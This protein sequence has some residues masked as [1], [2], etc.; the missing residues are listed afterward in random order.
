MSGV[1]QLVIWIR[2][3]S[4]LVFVLTSGKAKGQLSDGST[5]ASFDF[6]AKSAKIVPRFELDSVHVAEKVAA[7]KRLGIP[8][9]YGIVEQMDVDIRAEGIKTVIGNTV[10]WQYELS[11]PDALSLGVHFKTYHLPEGA[12][13]FI[14][15]PDKTRLRGGFSNTNG[16]EGNQLMLGEFP[17]NRLVIEYDEPLDATFNGELVIGSVSKAYV[18]FASVARSNIQINCPEGADWQETKHAVCLMTFE[19][20]L[21]S[22]YCSGALVNNVSEDRTPY[23]LTANHCIDSQS[24]ARTL[25]TY[26]NYENSTCTSSDASKGQTLSGASLMATNTYSD[27]CLLKL[28]EYP[29]KEYAP[30]FAGWNASNDLPTEGTCIHHPEGGAKSIAIDHNPISTNNY[31]VQWDNNVY[32]EIGTHWEA[33]YDVGTDA[34]GSS[35]APLFDENQ[36]IIGQLHGGD[37]TSSL[38]GRFSL[39]WD[40]SSTASKQLK[41]WLDPDDT[42]TLRLDGID[43]NKI[44]EAHFTTDATVACLNTPVA[45]TDHSKYQPT[46]WKW[47][48]EPSTFEFVNGSS[49]SS[50]NPEVI[51]TNDGS[52]SVSLS[53]TNDNGANELTSENLILSTSELP[54]A[55]QGLPDEMTVCGSLLNNYQIIAEGANE[56]TFDVTAADNFNLTQDADTLTLNLKDDVRQYGSFDTYVKVTGSHGGCSA[57][58]SILMHVIIPVNDD[59]THAIALKLGTNA[60]FNNECG[61]EQTNEPNPPTAGCTLGNN[62]CPPTPGTSAIDNSVWFTFKGTSNGKL[63]IET[64]GFDTQIAVYEA[65]SAAAILSGNTSN[66]TFLA[67]N[68]NSSTGNEAAIKDLPVELGKTYWLQVDGADGADGDFIINLLSNTVEVYPN[69]SD[70]IFH[71]TISSFQGGEAQL[72]VFTISG[73]QILSK[74]VSVSNDSNTVDLNLSGF[75]TGLYLFRATINGLVMTKKLMLLKN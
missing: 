74:T 6:S 56:Y 58:D 40:H 48:I 35:G 46:S 41:A 67:A 32:S 24:L 8:N 12:K 71:L 39:S 31:R 29:P 47:S 20:N 3:L 25:V 7:D 72:A 57:S 28:S 61:T 23:F 14:Y 68:D 17:G 37:D 63:S 52:Y 22:Y 45:L 30:F 13:V 43:Y 1:K 19:D 21:Y 33:F 65:R 4:L 53:V 51:F 11:C 62:W 55:L 38:F 16:S 75:R 42:R 54:V 60:T 66:Y 15:R 70:G 59:V 18:D 49:A 69:P 44:P 26:F 73:Q 5:P 64:K 27:F 34:S 10:V 2:L 9:R 36:R 50:Q